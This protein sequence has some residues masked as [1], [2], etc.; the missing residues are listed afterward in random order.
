MRGGADL[1]RLCGMEISWCMA[2][3]HFAH[4][5]KL[6]FS[7]SQTLSPFSL[8]FSTH[9]FKR[10]IPLFS[11]RQPPAQTSFCLL[12]RITCSRQRSPVKGQMNLTGRKTERK[13]RTPPKAVLCSH[14]SRCGTRRRAKN[15]DFWLFYLVIGL[16]V[17]EII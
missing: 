7:L 17:L 12:T 6:A 10:L 5:S 11:P 16:L 3:F 14:T 15:T 2:R 1:S 8:H 9:D 13:Q 4:P